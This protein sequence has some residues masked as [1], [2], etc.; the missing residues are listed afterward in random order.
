[1]Q[2]ALLAD[3][4]RVEERQLSEAFA[5]RGHETTLVSPVSISA[6]FASDGSAHLHVSGAA[7]E[8]FTPD[9]A[10]DRGHDD[11]EFHVE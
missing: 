9:L 1:M 4:L 10:L 11:A 6:G 2:I 3:R 8:L 7:A 5:S